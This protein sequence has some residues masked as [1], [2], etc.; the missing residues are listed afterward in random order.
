MPL[1]ASILRLPDGQNFEIRPVFSGMQFQ[2]Q[3]LN[4]QNHPFPVGWTIV[5][6]TEQDG[7]PLPPQ[8]PD[9]AGVTGTSNGST[10]KKLHAW[11]KPTLLRD[12]LFISSISNPSYNDFKPAASPTRQIAMMLWITLY[13]YFHQH[14]PEPFIHSDATKDTPDNAKPRG[15]WRISIKRDGVLRGRNL[16]PKLERMGLITSLNSA[17][18]TNP[19][20]NADGWDDMFVSRRMFWQI[21]GRLFLFTLQPNRPNK[22]FPGSPVTSRPAS[23]V[24]N[25]SPRNSRHTPSP[26]P[27]GG[28][29]RFDSDLI[30]GLPPMLGGAPSFPIGPFYSSSH[31]PTYYP[32]APPIYTIT[33][34]VRHPVRPKPPRMGEVFYTRFIPSVGQYLSLRVASVSPGPVPYWGPI[35]PKPPGHPEFLHLSDSALLERWMGNQR[36]KAFWGSYEPKF[37]TNAMSMR[38]SF[39]V[40]GLWDGIPF[41]YF[42]IYWVKEDVF[43][44]LLGDASDWDRGLHVLVGEEWSRG[45][46]PFWLSSLVHWCYT[47]D[48]RTM[49]VCLEPRIDN[50]RY[51]PAYGITISS[52]SVSVLTPMLSPC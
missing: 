9:Q 31:L 42:E 24:R 32:P 43:G 34:S 38:H 21:P 27:R 23:P 10:A 45:R 33:N 6:R 13:W 11:S 19:A 1:S 22:S 14:E 36:V 51:I 37:L 17:V 39:P 26:R 30:G 18:G 3:Q 7:P 47:A 52:R 35:G 41:G 44:K 12:C 25:E 2:S 48:Y 20:D 8:S 29:Q 50:A 4:E 28:H 16:I 40:I 46:V 5:I 15:E 49:N